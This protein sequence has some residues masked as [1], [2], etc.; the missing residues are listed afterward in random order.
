MTKPLLVIVN[1]L[2]GAGKTTLA[3]RLAA[4]SGLPVLH[5]D[6]IIETLFDSLECSTYGRPVMLGKAGFKL[7]YY[8][9]GALLAARQHLIVEGFFRFP[10]LSTGEFLALQQ[11]HDFE[12]LQILCQADGQVLLAR[13]TGRA[14]TAQRHICHRDHLWVEENRHLLLQGPH[15]GLALDGLTIEIDTTV[16]REET[17]QHV[18]QQV[19]ARIAQG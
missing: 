8:T 13:Y 9:S 15:Q 14:G 10:E 1:G 16:F 5:R 19:H 18:F 12:P 4:D 2:P 11:M 6:E 7:L 17:Y 3:K